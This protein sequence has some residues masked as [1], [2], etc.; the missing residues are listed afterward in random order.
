MGYKD[1]LG[2]YRMREDSMTTSKTKMIK[3]QW[4]IYRKV[5]KMNPISSVWYLFCWGINGVLKYKVGK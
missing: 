5:L 2:D 4:N 3:P 1:V